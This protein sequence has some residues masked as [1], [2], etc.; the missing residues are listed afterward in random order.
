MIPATP[1]NAAQSQQ[2]PLVPGDDVVDAEVMFTSMLGG[3][4]EAGFDAVY[5]YI[6]ENTY[7]NTWMRFDAALLVVFVSDEEEQ[8]GSHFID[9]LQFISW[10]SN[11]RPS[12]FLSSIINLPLAESLCTPNAADVGL[13]YKQVTQHFNGVVIDICSDD[14]STGVEA[15]SSLVEPIEELQLSH[16]PLIDTIRVFV[17][18]QL[19]HG[20]SYDV[21][22]NKITFTPIPGAGDLIEVGYII[23]PAS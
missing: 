3:G 4:G 8:S 18:G 20:W 22:L 21:T 23:D 1:N 13:K 7:S 5:A 16:T 19:D 6:A 14:W 12:V 10:Y 17:N 11:V 2:F 9:V 15:A